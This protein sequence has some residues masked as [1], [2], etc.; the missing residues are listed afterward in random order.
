MLPRLTLI[1][2]FLL[3][4]IPLAAQEPAPADLIRQLGSSQ[5]QERENASRALDR[6]GEKALKELAKAARDPD[7]E[8]RRRA[9]QLYKKI[10]E[11]LL[12]ER[13]LKPRQIRLQFKNTALSKAFD[14]V[15]FQIGIIHGVEH[16]KPDTLLNLDT[17][18]VSVWD[19][20]QQ[21]WRASGYSLLD[22]PP[23]RL[24]WGESVLRDLEEPY[25][26]EGVY[27]LSFRKIPAVPQDSRGPFLFRALPGPVKKDPSYA[28]FLEVRPDPQTGVQAIEALRFTKILNSQGDPNLLLWSK[29]PS[30][31]SELDV[32]K[33][34]W[35][36]EARNYEKTPAFLIP[37]LKNP[38]NTTTR[39]KEI[40]GSLTARFM[41]PHPAF[42]IKDLAKAQGK[43]LVE[44]GG[45]SL[46]LL[47][48]ETL[49]EGDIYLR[50]Q[51][52]HF[53]PLVHNA[54]GPRVVRPRPGFVAF[55]G[56]ADLAAQ[57]LEVRDGQG[58]LLP[59][60]KMT[61]IPLPNKEATGVELHLTFQGPVNAREPL[62]LVL[63]TYYPLSVDVPFTLR[64]VPLR[65]RER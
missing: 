48:M 28:F 12:A 43:R 62:R 33:Y 3:L 13:I 29:M 54:P 17:G 49:D 4:A 8:T 31:G 47:E 35:P 50:L 18:M 63:H 52:N 5:F 36:K 24:P 60:L 64:D 40:Q 39:Y 32:S 10:Q 34:P 37:V 27:G 7:I 46:T 20:L 58:R 61:S 65:M 42:V 11:R 45:A 25:L 51:L 59:R 30:D 6:L 55:L 57:S 22:T 14:Q 38:E 26:A 44:P 15:K 19:A 53:E 41:V 1:W 9:L 21:F 2:L 16:S 56:P 23:R